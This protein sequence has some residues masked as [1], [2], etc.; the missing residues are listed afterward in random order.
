MQA[1]VLPVADISPGDAQYILNGSEFCNSQSRRL[2]ANGAGDYITYGPISYSSNMVGRVWDVQLRA[3]NNS[4]AGKI[5]LEYGPSST[6]PWQDLLA[7]LDLYSATSGP[8]IADLGGIVFQDTP[9]FIQVAVVGKN[10]ASA[11]YNVNLDWLA[12]LP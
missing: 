12:F 8:K 2:A 5:R 3:A 1:E 10:A 4:V 9:T 7:P 6:G 11:G